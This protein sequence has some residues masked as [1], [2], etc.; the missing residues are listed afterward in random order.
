VDPN[1]PA[2]K[3]GLKPGDLITQ[4]GGKQIDSG[5]SRSAPDPAPQTPARLDVPGTGVGCA[6]RRGWTCRA[7]W[8]GCARRRGWV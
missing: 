2:G 1:G 6:R 4:F 5:P 3:A 8:A 7:P